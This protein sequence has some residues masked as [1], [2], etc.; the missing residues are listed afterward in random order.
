MT[1][2][3]EGGDRDSSTREK[4]NGDEELR[5]RMRVNEKGNPFIAFIHH[6]TDSI[7]AGRAALIIAGLNDELIKDPLAR[8]RWYVRIQCSCIK[9]MKEANV[10]VS[11]G[12]KER[13]RQKER[14]NEGCARL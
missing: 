2:K 7:M 13:G 10:C 9:Y 4:S 3:R 1:I 11:M 5:D 14:E 6:F 12:G 8:P